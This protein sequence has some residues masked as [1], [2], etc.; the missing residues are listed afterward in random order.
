[1]RD[2][3][4]KR[5][6]TE[7]RDQP[8]AAA[9]LAP[10]KQTL[11]ELLP[12]PSAPVQR[13]A[14]ASA[15]A[16]VM[17]SGPRPTLEDLFGQPAPRQPSVGSGPDAAPGPT[18][19][20]KTEDPA[21]PER[22]TAQ[23]TEAATTGASS[24]GGQALPAPVRQQMEG[25]FGADFSSVRVHQGPEA[26]QVGAIA[27]ARGDDL[28]FA[29]GHYRPGD[30]AGQ[31]VL[32]HELAHVVQ[33]RQGRVAATTQHK[34]IDVN[35]DPALEAQ[36]D[37]AGRR[38]AAGA[39]V[40]WSAGADATSAR[41]PVQRLMG[42]EAETNIPIADAGTNDTS[43]GAGRVRAF[44]TGGVADKINL[45]SGAGYAAETDHGPISGRI[46]QIAE[47]INYAI[48]ETTPKPK[49]SV[50][51]EPSTSSPQKAPVDPRFLTIAAAPKVAILEFKTHPPL[52]VEDP[53]G[54]G[55][56]EAAVRTMVDAIKLAQKLAL[57]G[58]SH[59]AGSRGAGVPASAD[60]KEFADT[61]NLPAGTITPFGD[62]LRS[63]LDPHLY[64]QTTTGI[65]LD[66]LPQLLVAAQKNP[67]LSQP[68]FGFPQDVQDYG[69]LTL[70]ASRD[71]AEEVRHTMKLG[72]PSL[73]GYLLL[74]MQYV[75]GNYVYRGSIVTTPK[76]VT[77]FLSKTSLHAAQDELDVGV[78]P[79]RMKQEDR[80]RLAE[81]IVRA[82]VVRAKAGLGPR[83]R[84]DEVGVAIPDW[85][86][87]VSQV[88]R[89]AG[90][91]FSA[92]NLEG[93]EFEPSDHAH[94]APIIDGNGNSRRARAIPL[95]ARHLGTSPL[96]DDLW[97]MVADIARTVAEV[98]AHK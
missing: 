43:T 40:P 30:R 35:A 24:S 87:W 17:R 36:A 80:Q 82:I 83:F 61:V 74:V 10:G 79:D 6:T 91:T 44:L 39:P 90:D 55:K 9:G 29:A 1:V 77:P 41:G 49:P 50:T 19:Q 38:A 84:D 62:E 33:Q 59:Y 18:I 57:V 64:V 14:A 42:V 86:V 71:A 93:R 56:F 4:G 21:A 96:P 2:F 47:S 26:A 20:R 63:M 46:H 23:S 51:K 16:P 67:K 85:A 5:S 45:A 7:S 92:K 68:G 75:F 58:F 13:E 65:L 88:L 97:A 89:G 53:T 98:N 48:Y 78:R 15:P 94:G 69:K 52:D 95:E 12:P 72:D 34:G 32:G 60:W 25:A 37:E 22:R 81:A 28:H 70:E 66:R 11:T 3:G 54:L 76:N 27:F 8:P 73:V 31:E